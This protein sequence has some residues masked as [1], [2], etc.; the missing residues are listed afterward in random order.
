M[1]SIHII[2]DDAEIREVLKELFESDD[3][4]VSTFNSAEDAHPYI[5]RENPDLILLDI[6]LPGMDGLT[7]LEKLKNE[8]EDVE[9]I[10]I[11]GQADLRSAIR[12]I[13]LGAMDYIRKPIDPNELKLLANHAIDR[14]KKREQLNY[15]QIKSHLQFGDIVGTSEP[16]Q[17]VYQFIYQVAESSKTTV[18]I[19]GET[20]TGK[21]LVARSIHYQS[22]RSKHPFIEVNCSAIQPSLLESELFGHEAGAF[23]DAKNRKKGL[24]ELAHDGTFFLDEVGDMNLASQ[25][26]LL[27]VLEEKTFRRVGGIKEIKIDARII[28]ASSRDL[29]QLVEEKKFRADLYY[30]LNVA[31]VRLPALRER[32]DD[33]LIL[34]NYFLDVFNKEFK[35]NIRSISPD[36]QKMLTRH[37]WVGNVREIRNVIERAVLFEQGDV[38]SSQNISLQ[39]ISSNEGAPVI[40]DVDL[41]HDFRLPEEGIS[42]EKLEQHLLK[43]ALD[44]SGGNKTRAAALLGLSRETMKYRLKKFKLS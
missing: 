38:L 41:N 26:K 22:P 8:L 25:S 1:V 20:G 32:D 27:K 30:R 5:L 24:L 17:K 42:L 9:V 14:R 40:I 7:Y 6:G 12:A 23:T 3:Y 15:L 4:E 19:R 10:M 28:S 36:A 21:G 11:T 31:S 44:R 37:P 18:L 16:M 13:K 34:A 39:Q 43:Q 35:R 29:M 2:D 33:I